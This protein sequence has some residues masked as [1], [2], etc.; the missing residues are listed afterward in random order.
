MAERRNFR[1]NF[2]SRG[3]IWNE[4]AAFK[5]ALFSWNKNQSKAVETIYNFA[6]GSETIRPFHQLQ[7]SP[8]ELTERFWLAAESAVLWPNACSERFHLKRFFIEHLENCRI[9][10]EWKGIQSGGIYSG[11]GKIKNWKSSLGGRCCDPADLGHSFATKFSFPVSFIHYFPLKGL[12]CRADGAIWRAEV[13]HAAHQRAAA[14]GCVDQITAKGQTV[15]CSRK[16]K[17]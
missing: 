17:V 10:M 8:E 14:T 16:D 6:F 13:A 3:G 11:D 9:V 1:P 7:T 2:A 15:T 12:Y 5:F 4:F